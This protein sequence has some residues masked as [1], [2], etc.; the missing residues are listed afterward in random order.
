M[1]YYHTQ[2]QTQKPQ[3]IRRQKAATGN[4]L[5][6]EA[7][8][9]VAKCKTTRRQEIKCI[10]LITC[11]WVSECVQCAWEVQKNCRHTPVF[12]KQKKCFFWVRFCCCFCFVGIENLNLR[13]VE[14]ASSVNAI[15]MD[16]YGSLD[17]RCSP[18]LSGNGTAADSAT[19]FASIVLWQ[20]LVCASAVRAITSKS[21]SY[22]KS[23]STIRADNCTRY[24]LITN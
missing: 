13:S 23:N 17:W 18:H 15:V 14:S 11:G 1:R 19:V 12:W 21:I 7:K 10:S 8:K 22:I 16:D 4:E 20:C 9:L 2:T 5:V 24:S 3:K 6:S